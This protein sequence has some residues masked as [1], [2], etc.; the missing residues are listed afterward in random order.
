VSVAGDGAGAGADAGVIIGNGAVVVRATLRF[1]TV[2]VVVIVEF[3][4]SSMLAMS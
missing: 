4:P 1:I 2:V 3:V